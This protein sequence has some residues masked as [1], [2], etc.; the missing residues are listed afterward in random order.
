M[1]HSAA[2]CLG[3][4]LED[5]KP[6]GWN[7]LKSHLA[8]YLVVDANCWPPFVRKELTEPV[9]LLVPCMFPREPGP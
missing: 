4:E 9:W 7:F 8:T 5:L 3:P 1:L 6:G 2:Q